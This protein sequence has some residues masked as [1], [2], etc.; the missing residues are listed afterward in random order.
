MDKTLKLT[1]GAMSK[2]G[3][4]VYESVRAGSLDPDLEAMN[5]DIDNEQISYSQPIDPF[6][7]P[8]KPQA[9]DL[10][11]WANTQPV[12]MKYITEVTKKPEKLPLHCEST[13]PNPEGPI[14]IASTSRNPLETR[15][16]PL[17]RTNSSARA[18]LGPEAS[19]SSSKPPPSPDGALWGKDRLAVLAACQSVSER[20]DEN[21][22]MRAAPK[23]HAKR[24]LTATHLNDVSKPRRASV[25]RSITH[26]NRKQKANLHSE[27]T[28]LGVNFRR[29][30][31]TPGTVS[32]SYTED[33]LY[34]SPDTS[35]MDL[36]P[37]SSTLIASPNEQSPAV[38][39]RSTTCSNS[40]LS[41][42]TLT[43]ITPAPV[44]VPKIQLHPLLT[45]NSK[46]LPAPSKQTSPLTRQ[47]PVPL[48]PP[49]SQVGRP[50]VLGM[51]RAHTAPVP[52]LHAL[53]SR[54]KAFK[55]PLL[56]QPVPTQAN[57]HR[58]A[59]AITSIGND[60]KSRDTRL[61]YAQQTPSRSPSPETNADTSYD[62]ISFGMDDEALELTMRQYD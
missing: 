52:V 31:S 60:G 6:P 23:P 7:S 3:H 59:P 1:K 49:L 37:S 24:K 57:L 35:M 43:Q 53:P 50:P 29:S 26:D 51:R 11:G 44:L 38:S 61:E 17:R 56:S 10:V 54:Q 13:W 30:I 55:P 14:Q 36:D 47:P 45:P 16:R 42:D 9:M 18:R 8:P 62:D 25:P 2:E 19:S 5:F 22:F 4:R 39:V 20:M 40:S 15:S 12:S 48:H 32:S 46:R 34:E 28:S 27:S 33:V 21:A 41:I 58:G